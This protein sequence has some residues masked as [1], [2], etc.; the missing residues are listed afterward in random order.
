MPSGGFTGSGPIHSGSCGLADLVTVTRAVPG[1]V[2]DLRDGWAGRW[3]AACR[4]SGSEVVCPVRDL[5]SFPVPGCEPVRRFPGAGASGIAS[6]VHG[7]YLGCP[8]GSRAWR[9]PGC[10]WRWISRAQWQ[11]VI[12]QPFR[13]RFATEDGPV[14]RI[15]DVLAVAADG[16]WLIDVRPSDRIGEADRV[17]FAASAEAALACG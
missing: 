3:S 4:V 12:C 1:E 11:K 9:K 15:P 10:C 7:E 2:L 13:L 5:G 6:A 17:K 14:E 8:T 16:T